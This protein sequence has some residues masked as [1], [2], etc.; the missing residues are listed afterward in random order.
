ME[1]S[2]YRD[3]NAG[4]KIPFAEVNGLLGFP[5]N[6]KVTGATANTNLSDDIFNK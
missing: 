4:V 5:I 6:Y 1:F 3:I 2:D